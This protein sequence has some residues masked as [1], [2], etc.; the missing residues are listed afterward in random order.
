[1]ARQ[2]LSPEEVLYAVHHVFLPPKL[3]QSGDDPKAM[4]HDTKLVA[5]VSDALQAFGLLIDPCSQGFVHIANC[6]IRRLRHIKDD[7]GF[8]IE[9]ELLRSFSDLVQHGGFIPVPVK[10]QNAAIIISQQG[11]CIIF[12]FSELSPRND[13]AMSTKGRLQRCFP[14][15]SV[16]VTKEI[17]ND[18]GCRSMLAHTI[19]KMSHQEVSEMKPKVVKARDQH[20]EERDTTSPD[21]VT[22]FLATV[23][24][25]MGQTTKTSCI[26]KNTREEVLWNDAALP[27]RRSPIWLFVRVALQL[28]FSRLNSGRLL[29]KEFMVVLM[30]RILRIAQDHSLDCD[31]LYCMTAKIS[32]R[33]I[34]LGRDIKPPWLQIVEEAALGARNHIQGCWNDIQ[35]QVDSRVVMPRMS[36]L[37]FEN[38]KHIFA[39]KLDL[40]I[41]Q[42]HSRQDI[43][44][45]ALFAPP[46]VSF[47][48]RK[49]IL[50]HIQSSSSDE[51]IFFHLF[52]LEDWVSSSLDAWL[53]SHITE[54]ESCY[55]LFCSM[56][57]YHR[58]AIQYYSQSPDSLS[59]ML[60]TVL[61]MWV[62]CD[63]SACRHHNLL[64][65]YD[66]EVPQELL[67]SLILPFK[68][69]MERLHRIETYIQ[70]RRDGAMPTNPPI[71][72]SF[73]H[74]RC[75]AV[76][77]FGTSSDHH[78][79]SER[80]E[81]EA[82]QEREQKKSEFH[83]VRQEYVRLMELHNQT[84]C[85]YD[86]AIDYTTGVTTRIHNNFCKSCRYR[87]SA[88]SLT[89]R[90]HEW[91]LPSDKFHAQSTV[92]ELQVPK[93]F[94][95]WRSATT[96][97]LLDVLESTY[98]TS[99]MSKIDWTL[100]KYLP[101]FHIPGT[102]R[103]ILGSTTKPNR[104]THRQ[105]KAISTATEDSVLVRNGLKY[106][107]YDVEANSLVSSIQVTDEIAG[108]CTYKL[109][110][111]SASLQT[112][113]HRPFHSPDGLSPNHVI[114]KQ[115]DCP[116]HL[117]LEEFKA[118][119]SLPV[120]HRIQWLNILTQLHMPSVDFRNLDTMFILL[121]ISR[122]AGPPSGQSVYRAS[123]EQLRDGTFVEKCLQGLSDALDRS[124]GSWESCHAVAGFISVAT[125]LLCLAPSSSLSAQCLSFLGKCRVLVYGWMLL[126]QDKTQQ[127]EEE[128]QRLDFMD[129][130]FQIAH[131]CVASFDVD[132]H[133]LW[134]LLAEP[135]EACIL[136]E[137]SITI[138][139]TMQSARQSLDGFHGTLTQRWRRLMCRTYPILHHQITHKQSQCLDLAIQKTWSAYVS[140][141]G[142]EPF[143][144]TVDYWLTTNTKPSGSA[145]SLPVQFNILTAELLVGGL[146]LC[147]LPGEYEK[148]PSYKTLFGRTVLEVMPAD[149]HGMRFSSKKAYRGYTVFFG[150]STLDPTEIAVV[151][152]KNGQALDLVPAKL[153]SD[154]LP[155]HF[156]ESY[157]HWYNRLSDTIEFR[158]KSDPWTASSTHWT[159]KRATLCW[160]LKREGQ[161]LA[162]PRSSLAKD[163]CRILAPL[164]D[165]ANIHI[166][167]NHSSSECVEIELPRL[168]LRFFQS[169]KSQK[170]Y[171]R[172]YR[173]MFVDPDQSIG[174]L[175]GLKSKLVLRDKEKN[176][177]VL[178]PD[179]QVSW[180]SANAHVQITVRHGSSKKVHPYDIDGTLGRLIDNGSL[181]SKLA[182]SYLHALTSY[183]L[184]DQLT[185]K[186]GTEQA[187]CILGS[188]A[189]RSFDCLTQKSLDIL[190]AIAGL[191]P[192]RTYYPRNER[193]MENV[194]WDDDVSFLSQDGALARTVG[195][196]LQQADSTKFFY[197][198]LCV[199]S[200]EFRRGS[201][202]LACRQSI[203]ASTFRVSGFGAENHTSELDTMYEARDV[204]MHSDRSMPTIWISKMVLESRQT[205]HLAVSPDFVEQLWALFNSAERTQGPTR[206]LSAEDIGYDAQWLGNT[207]LLLRK[208]W[209]QFHH[210][211][212]SMPQQFNR[213]QVMMWLASMAYSKD[214]NPQA[215][216]TLAAFAT[217][218]SIRAI[219]IPCIDSFLI[220][221]IARRATLQN[222]T[223][224]H[225]TPF[226]MCPESNLSCRLGE[227]TW[228]LHERQSREFKKNQDAV[229]HAF[230]DFIERQWV[231]KTPYAPGDGDFAT[232]IK[233]GNAMQEI[234][235]HWRDWYHGHLFHGYLDDICA[236]LQRCPVNPVAA[237]PKEEGN[238]VAPQTRQLRSFINEQDLFQL[239][240]ASLPLD[241][242]NHLDLCRPKTLEVDEG[243]QL[244]ELVESL[245]ER[246]SRR[247]EH[248][249]VRDL[250]RSLASLSKL[251]LSHS[252]PQTRK[253]I[254]EILRK[255]LVQRQAH[256]DKV[257]QALECAVGFN[258]DF[259]ANTSAA[260][261][262]SIDEITR[263][264]MAPR[265]SQ[266]F[267]LQQLAR[268]RWK[269]L[270]PE[271]KRSI[272]DYG[273]ALTKLQ[274]AARMLHACGN[275]TDL[276]KELLNPGHTN[277]DPLEYPESLLLEVESGIMIREIQEEIASQMRDPPKDA[278][279]VMQ[280]NMGEGKSSVIIPAVA[281]HLA[282]GTRL[283]R[284]VVAKPQ[285]KELLRMLVSK[286][287]GL[288]NHQVYHMPF[289]RK[290]KLSTSDATSIDRLCKECMERGGVLLVQPEHILSFKLMGIESHGSGQEDLGR[291]L[292]NTQHLFTMSSRDLVDESDENFSVKFELVYT[293]GTQR[294]IELSPERWMLI[295]RL[296]GIVTKV[297]EAIQRQ[298]PAS[299]ELSHQI[300]GRFPRTRIVRSDA[301]E[302]LL[303]KVAQ[304][305]C[306]VGLSGF[307]VGRQPKAIREAVFQYI[308]DA[309]LSATQAD[310]VEG[311][312][313]IFTQSMKS[314]LFLLRGL[315][316]GGV[317]EFVLGHKRWRVDYGL[318]P[319]R[320]PK[321]KLAVP[322]RAKDNP[323]PRSE[324]SHPDVVIVLTSLSY[325]YGGLADDDLFLSFDHLIKS[326]QADIE[327]QEWVR[328][329][330][331]LPTSFQ[332]LAGVNMKDRFQV[333]SQIFPHLRMAKS[334]IDYFLARIVFPKEMKEFPQRLSASGWDIGQKKVYP[335]TGF[336]GTIDSH[337]LLPLEVGYLDLEKQRHT[338]A[339]VL[340]HLLQPV[341]AVQYLKRPSGGV[342]D[343]ETLLRVV[344]SMERPVQVILDVGAQI[345]E[346]TNIQIAERWLKM[347]Q[348][349]QEK[350]AVVFF[351]DHDELC[352]IDRKGHVEQLHISPYSRHLDVCLVFLG[353]AH[354]RGTDLKLPDHYRAAVTLGANLTKDRLVQACM[355]MRKLGKGQSVV[356]FVPEEIDSKIRALLGTPRGATLGVSD[357]MMWAFSETQRDLC[358][359]MPLWAMQGTRFE[360]HKAIWAQVTGFK[361]I[362]MSLEQALKFLEDEAQS[363]EARYRPTSRISSGLDQ[364]GGLP[365]LHLNPS[366][367]AIRKRCEEFDTMHSKASTLQEEQERELSPEV[368]AER[369][370]ER[371]HPAVPRPHRLHKHLLDFLAT[372]IVPDKSPAFIDAFRA[373]ENTSA[374]EYL[375]VSEFP[376]D[377]LITS[378][379]ANTV[380][381]EG[382]Q[383]Y[384]DSYQRPIQWVLTSSGG[385][386]GVEHLVIISPYEAQELMPKMSTSKH[387]FLHVY[388][389]RPHL[390][391]RPLDELKLHTIPQLEGNWHLPRHLRLQLNLFAGQLYFDSFDDYRET[392]E[393]MSL[394]WKPA[395]AGMTVE[396]DGFVVRELKDPGARLSQSPVAFLKILLTKIRRDCDKIDKTH[397]GKILGGEILK[398]E[399]V[400]E[401]AENISTKSLEP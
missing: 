307:P 377:I 144:T 399:D 318:D 265:V 259:M 13:A 59:I 42:F 242:E 187:L 2:L 319:N 19:A 122:Q 171:S 116:D 174:T 62:A 81:S 8:L 294:P 209:F 246:A 191:S 193:A 304:E 378:D 245:R 287:G 85:T 7:E 131:I 132:E 317:L 38:S 308:T 386:K 47:N 344:T 275:E 276:L 164:E 94:D 366:L 139:T 239:C 372:G 90:V 106:Q 221:N 114:S 169:W 124:K 112:F 87:K 204:S 295:Q 68:D 214:R 176:R 364:V 234:R 163:I 65:K 48:L 211:L 316:A 27:W 355:R 311:N 159:M 14:A 71:F 223:K 186:T 111:Q 358:R 334:A 254:R 179:G 336:S 25:A 107:Y 346:L 58:T 224:A 351:N 231:C 312:R 359:S 335:T 89:I 196:I 138:Q 313:L 66:P 340:K 400:S 251:N 369:Q 215:L 160:I 212:R 12:E 37:I 34:K 91:P 100:G 321:T 274:W 240:A 356:F 103:L 277:W 272:V 216:Q 130:T 123:H 150:L 391:F 200:R 133:H 342:S 30:S 368:Q 282:D 16:S 101:S 370:R 244:T 249:Y 60:L 172:Q 323:T 46:S 165:E 137:T 396:A 154:L 301:K 73:G 298:L 189:V 117:S 166:M 268:E 306:T 168:Q 5:L 388:A 220:R 39:A 375:D 82:E 376:S 279:A 31:M 343:A 361:G 15:S 339:L 44:D 75:F 17:F 161:S 270:S 258:S 76:Q 125:R 379:Y 142:W 140:G 390:A 201:D 181:E 286:L 18:L 24:S 203:R 260:S 197:P 177:K 43:G 367:A 4:V 354:T 337:H 222:I 333:V 93:P 92:F 218:P 293:M 63:K 20:I 325:Y 373:L 72:S 269:L 227:A 184:P 61:E 188:A 257:Y 250:E 255:H 235:E 113:L 192:I 80:I 327:Y 151:A 104:G 67:Q 230:V 320:N 205:L 127:S 331:K 156:S 26:W 353:Q 141:D 394:A 345:L 146:P 299:I 338:N 226:H 194:Q 143:S 341:N 97:V 278:N 198:D 332:N 199:E 202:V 70:A 208:Y 297:A 78:R 105:G 35:C 247:H 118:M 262:R 115:A 314:A 315:I 173:G 33:L 53:E 261:Q 389:P 256:A 252:M 382:R 324:F 328:D 225:L 6:A 326:D 300:T 83:Q 195:S 74:P 50:P 387:V 153:F 152:F 392:C 362:D 217:I 263:E 330:P 393:V 241:Q 121:Q 54:E 374:A 49:E 64:S 365:N 243:H 292:L 145:N 381:L 149:V 182:L 86:N 303:N 41:G 120:G 102:R 302:L 289:S 56:R 1:M 95:D 155:R 175:V 350:E 108:R 352:V 119:A 99:N 305:V 371:P 363:L 148:H 253:P 310:L 348:V 219:P 280:L 238:K 167:L 322:F 158:P 11:D 135:S 395:E 273:L 183:C 385:G 329:A 162:S 51:E 180:T 213:F 236:A 357:V 69:Q 36:S 128:E 126:L 210:S 264:L 309:S 401:G 109:S 129:R 88:Q 29:Y 23:V 291:I 190:K 384:A 229:C 110:K 281:A 266:T 84:D 360:H 134:R 283:V 383:P 207:S 267:F 248:N 296:L 347:L 79:L 284:V 52:A 3:P 147:R 290:L 136:I 288:L 77:Y 10:S 380:K 21:L 228:E 96:Y 32:R 45:R 397:W 57:L 22:D 28:I 349:G 170:L 285:A 40:F 398:K 206:V 178:L 185:G 55:H 98:D 271:W 233:G 237:L 9:D 232:Y 157:T